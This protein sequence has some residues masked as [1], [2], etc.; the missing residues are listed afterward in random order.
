[1]AVIFK[2]EESFYQSANI[3]VSFVGHPLVDKVVAIAPND[4][5][6]RQLG[7]DLDQPVVGLF[8]GSR[9]IEIERLLPLMLKTAASLLV[10]KPNIRFV[11]PVAT[12]LDYDSIQQRCEQSSVDIVLTRDDIY[13]LIP[14]CDAII[15]CSGTAT[16]EIALLG[17][18]M[19]IIYKMSWL[20][21]LIMSRLIT[22]PYI[23]LA[24]IVVN[25]SI[26][27]E[28]LQG[29]A[30]DTNISAEIIKL[31]DDNNYRNTMIQNLR[32][33]RDNLGEGGGSANLAKLALSFVKDS[34]NSD[35]LEGTR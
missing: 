19:C 20:S 9:N 29:N 23:G 31:L 1:M 11:M 16:L 14:C 4:L 34:T 12:T 26:V 18:P 25:R 8:P 15:T 13:S 33:V 5:K 10:Q 24:N 27:R 17:V 21:Y 22:I 32:L 3:P 35:L 28:F 2:F 30:T 6:R 7:L